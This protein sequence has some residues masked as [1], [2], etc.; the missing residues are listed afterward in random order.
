VN[1]GPA[2]AMTA[3]GAESQPSPGLTSEDVAALQQMIAN[4]DLE[5]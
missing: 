2:S 5:V 1:P 4:S 3:R